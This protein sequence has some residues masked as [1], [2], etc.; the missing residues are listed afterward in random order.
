MR[1]HTIPALWQ[2]RICCRQWR[3]RQ[4]LDRLPASESEPY[5]LP[6]TPPKVLSEDGTDMVRQPMPQF[7]DP[8]GEG[9]QIE[10]S[11]GQQ[12]PEVTSH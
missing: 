11:R 2:F 12:T 6:E 5:V 8:E 9:K 7:G 3:A 4:S 1:P 10:L